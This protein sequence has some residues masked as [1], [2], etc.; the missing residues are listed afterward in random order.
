[1]FVCPSCLPDSALGPAGLAS[2]MGR[3]AEVQTVVIKY[4]LD[5]DGP[6]STFKSSRTLS[7]DIRAKETKPAL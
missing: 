3:R 7:R 6:H 5:S 4:Q 2:F 1:M